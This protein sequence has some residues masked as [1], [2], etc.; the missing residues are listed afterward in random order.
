MAGQLFYELLLTVS[1][2]Q[3]VS[4]FLANSTSGGWPRLRRHATQKK[5]GFGVFLRFHS[6]YGASPP[7]LTRQHGE[8]AQKSSWI[9]FGRQQGRCSAGRNK[10]E[11][12]Q[13]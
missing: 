10:K 5:A 11:P 4:A 9:S 13:A 12:E 8:H 2:W 7:P 3:P 6:L 1:A